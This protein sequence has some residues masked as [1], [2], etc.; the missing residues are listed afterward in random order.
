MSDNNALH[1]AAGLAADWKGRDPI[2]QR[3]TVFCPALA[4]PCSCR[5]AARG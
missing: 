5:S 1:L 4:L 2:E 3:R